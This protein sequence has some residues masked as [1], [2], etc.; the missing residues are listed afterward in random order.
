MKLR[1]TILKYHSWYL[2]QI[3]LQIMLLPIQIIK[4]KILEL[5]KLLTF[6]NPQYPHIDFPD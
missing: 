4:I 6:S 5:L 2:S 3:L 1:I